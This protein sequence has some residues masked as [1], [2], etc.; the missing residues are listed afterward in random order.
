MRFDSKLVDQDFQE[1][2]NFGVLPQKVRHSLFAIYST[3]VS[4]GI[5]T[6]VRDYAHTSFLTEQSEV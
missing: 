6:I 2:S 4:R 1:R 3:V 5:V